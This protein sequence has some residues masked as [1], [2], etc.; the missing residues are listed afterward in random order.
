[1]HIVSHRCIFSDKQQTAIRQR[2]H[3]ASTGSRS[4]LFYYY[5]ATEGIFSISSTKKYIYI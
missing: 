4:I 3:E 2:S 1:M 5:I